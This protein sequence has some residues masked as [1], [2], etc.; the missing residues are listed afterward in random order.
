MAPVP[1]GPRWELEVRPGLA[2]FARDELAAHPGVTPL[3]PA[4]AGE[5]DDAHAAAVPF[6]CDGP[7]PGPDAVR[8][9]TSLQR[10]VPFDV[11]RPKALLGD[12]AARTVAAELRGIRMRG[13]FHGLRLEAAGADTPVARRLRAAWADAVGLPDA[14]EDGDLRVRLRRTPDAVGRGW[15]VVI[16]TTPRPWSVRPWRVV[17]RPGG[18]DATVAAAAW[19]WLG[20]PADQR[21]VNAMCGGGTLLAERLALGPAAALVGVDLDAD[22]LAAAAANLAAAGAR[23]EGDLLPPDDGAAAPP[24]RPRPTVR[25]RLADATAT[26]LPDAAFDVLVADPPWGDAVG[27]TADLPD[28]YAALLREA[29]RLVV[30]G[31]RAW[32]VTHALRAFDAAL[33]AA[34][35]AWRP[36]GTLRVFHGGHRPAVHRLRR[37]EGEVPER[38]E[39]DLLDSPS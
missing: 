37:T 8:T 14:P 12:V 39:G 20:T 30:P 6:R 17:D 26:D 10:V 23:V 34:G 7:P 4:V 38:R 35:D 9:A 21:V 32:I 15:E 27:E 33:A 28:L 2:P 22:A 13:T 11:P 1:A 18:L 5:P 16:R 19:R 36:D 29:A 3:P 25:L 24:G 31:G